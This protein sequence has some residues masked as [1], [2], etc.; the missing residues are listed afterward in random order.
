LEVRAR[1]HN[2]AM[3]GG[4]STLSIIDSGKQ[5]GS[6]TDA[7]GLDQIKKDTTESKLDLSTKSIDI[8]RRVN[9]LIICITFS[10]CRFNFV[11]FTYY[12]KSPTV[13]VRIYKSPTMGQG[14]SMAR[15]SAEP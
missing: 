15:I 4:R 10:L 11:Y 8:L 1:K 6:N 5:T 9:T 12:E 14:K 13:K 2:E 7:G 3:K